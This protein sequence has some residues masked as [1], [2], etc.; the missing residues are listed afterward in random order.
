MWEDENV[1]NVKIADPRNL[2]LIFIFTHLHI[3]TFSN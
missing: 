3:F 1:V 2:Y